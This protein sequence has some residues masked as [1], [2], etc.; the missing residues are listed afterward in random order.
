MGLRARSWTPFAAPPRSAIGCGP[1]SNLACTWLSR[2]PLSVDCCDR[3]ARTAKSKLSRVISTV[4][5][6]RSMT[7]NYD[8]IAEQYKHSKQQPW[9]THVEAFTLMRLIGDPTGKAVVDIACGEG[10][11]TR[12]IR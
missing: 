5:R 2:F 4:D 7:T 8:P 3:P 1:S 9:R 11:Y 12:T 10:F 6:G